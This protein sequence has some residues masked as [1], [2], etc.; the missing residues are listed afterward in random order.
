[1]D[2]SEQRES[3]NVRDR[4]GQ[5]TM[6]A[7]GGVGAAVIGAILYFVFGVNPQGLIPQAGPAA[8]AKVDPND[9]QAIFVKKIFGSTEDVWNTQFRKV[10]QR[11]QE[12]KLNIF[13][14]SVQSACGHA[15]A[16]VGPFYCPGDNEV[17]LDLDFFQVMEKQLKAGGDFARAYVVAHEVGHHVQNLL[18]YSQR[19]EEMKRREGDNKP[20]VRLELQ[21]D[22]LA[23]VWGHYAQHALKLD[24]RDLDSALNA[25]FQIGDDTLQKRGSGRVVPEK[26]THGTSQQR[27]AA[28]KAGFETGKFDRP[29]L[30]YFFVTPYQDLAK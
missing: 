1:M 16:A 3:G 25:A 30:D 15:D 7:G 29:A 12:P 19:A 18:G 11:Y 8:G 22:Y 4:R 20:S 17:Y 6:I 14:G 26:F 9:P 21:A 5:G 28:F 2:L 13:R 27:L 23:G 10:A 24:R